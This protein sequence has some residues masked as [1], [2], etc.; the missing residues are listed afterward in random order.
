VYLTYC[1]IPAGT[2]RHT[3]YLKYRNILAG[4]D[5]HTV[6][7]TYRS[8]LAGTDSVSYIPQH[9]GRYKQFI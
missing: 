3:V 9:P 5:R 1:T 4:T 8:I 6:Y 7:L 2:E